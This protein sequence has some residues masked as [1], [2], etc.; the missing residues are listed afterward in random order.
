MFAVPRQ[1]SSL[2]KLS[3]LADG[4]V[5]GLGAL[6]GKAPILRRR[7]GA[8]AHDLSLEKITAQGKF[9]RLCREYD[10]ILTMEKRHIAALCDIAGNARQVTVWSLG[11]RA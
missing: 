5:R 2:L 8:D 6:V 7:R 4:C 3:S 9:P 10:L 1:R 11:R